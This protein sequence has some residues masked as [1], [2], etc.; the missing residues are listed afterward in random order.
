ML[1]LWKT[2]SR[3]GLEGIGRCKDD[4]KLRVYFDNRSLQK[5]H[6]FLFMELLCWIGHDKATK[7]V[8]ED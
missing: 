3:G 1:P 2:H 7:R 5:F 6:V 8:T 4:S